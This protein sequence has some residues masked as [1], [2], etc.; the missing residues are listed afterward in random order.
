MMW[1]SADKTREVLQGG[2]VPFATTVMD[3]T[4]P[5]LLLAPACRRVLPGPALARPCRHSRGRHPP[6][7][8][9]GRAAPPPKAKLVTD[10]MVRVA[11]LWLRS[12][13]VTLPGAAIGCAARV[14]S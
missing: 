6:S 11:G 5:K 2:R 12:M 8:C 13:P 14:P 1:L 3:A 10:L 4:Y 7:F 9:L